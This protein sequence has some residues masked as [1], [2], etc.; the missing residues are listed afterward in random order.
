METSLSGVAVRDRGKR[1]SGKLAAMVFAGRVCSGKGANRAADTR[2]ASLAASASMRAAVGEVCAASGK[3]GSVLSVKAGLLSN[4]SGCGSP[5]TAAGNAVKLAEFSG[6][7]KAVGV[8][9][10]VEAVTSIPSAGNGAR[11]FPAGAPGRSAERS[12]ASVAG[13]SIPGSGVSGV[14]ITSSNSE[15]S[16]CIGAGMAAAERVCPA[17]AT[18][19]SCTASNV[20]GKL[21]GRGGRLSR[22]C[23]AST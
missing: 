10:T 22:G 3:G 19:L 7:A 15:T 14:T 13:A 16:D 23:T 12:E 1:A 2:S 5:P 21:S 9:K 8:D 20:S 6:I 17:A 18:V 11:V 4:R